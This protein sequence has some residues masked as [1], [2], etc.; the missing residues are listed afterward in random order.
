MAFCGKQQIN[1]NPITYFYIG[2]SAKHK[3]MY[4]AR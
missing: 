3:Q 2:N 1:I 4:Y